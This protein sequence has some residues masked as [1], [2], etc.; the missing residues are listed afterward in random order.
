VPSS[1]IA[2]CLSIREVCKLVV[3]LRPRG[4][5]GSAQAVT[6]T[7]ESGGAVY[8]MRQDA[9]WTVAKDTASGTA[10]GP[11]AGGAEPD[12][13]A[14]PSKGS[15]LG[16]GGRSACSLSRRVVGPADCRD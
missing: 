12:P 13:E 3:Q 8:V 11:S 10:S 16:I 4:R 6:A 9:T 14:A 15:L 2:P 7:Y 1:A 5:T